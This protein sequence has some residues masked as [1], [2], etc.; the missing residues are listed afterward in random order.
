MKKSE[1]FGYL[2]A[3]LGI[4]FLAGI[5]FAPTSGKETRENLSKKMEECMGNTCDMMKSKISCIREHIDEYAEEL[6]TKFGDSD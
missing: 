3:T 2:L 6:K 1:I 4:G 5:L